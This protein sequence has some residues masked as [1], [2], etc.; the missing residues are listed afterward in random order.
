[1]HEHHA[2]KQLGQHFLK[3]PQAISAMLDAGHITEGDVVLEIGPGKGVLT[4]ALLHRGARVVAVEKDADLVPLLHELFANEIKTKQLTIVQED[5][6]SFDPVDHGLSE[7]EYKLIANIPYYITGEIFELFLEQRAQPSVMVV[8]VQKEVAQR[9][10]ARDGKESILS[11]AVKAYGTP[12]LVKTVSKKYFSPAPKVDSAIISVDDISHN[13]F[14]DVEEKEFFALVKLGF[15]QKRKKVASNI[16]SLIPKESFEA[17][18]QNHNLSLDAR[19][20]TLT[21]DHWIELLRA[22]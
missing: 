4:K 20:E 21:I 9:I 5:I 6:R 11:I 10:V 14:T 17:F 3:S 18:A 22:Q 16:A 15:S 13:N 8:L 7:G 2:K 19:P 1:M 12:R